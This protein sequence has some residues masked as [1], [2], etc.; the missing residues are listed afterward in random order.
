MQGL[1]QNLHLSDDDDDDDHDDDDDDDDDDYAWT[2]T[3][4]WP[5]CS[6]SAGHC[7]AEDVQQETHSKAGSFRSVSF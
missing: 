7:I 3:S 2:P 1:K 4:L 5:L 6:C